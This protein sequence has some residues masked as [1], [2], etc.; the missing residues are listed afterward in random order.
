MLTYSLMLNP[1]A[2]P[3]RVTI[4][5][6]PTA[7]RSRRDKLDAVIAELEKLGC[8]VNVLETTAPGHAEKIAQQLDEA[9]VDI[10]AAAGGDGTVNEVV[11]G[12]K[13]KP[14]ALAVI[15][16][17]TAN[18]LADEVGLG[19]KAK[20]VAEAIAFGG[21]RPIRVGNAN[22]RRFVM[23]AGAGFDAEVVDGVQLSLKKVIGPL[24][25]VWE[26]FRQV[27]IYGWAGCCVEVDGET[28]QVVSAIVCNGRSYGGPFI[29]APEASLEADCF[30]VVMFTRS[31]WFNVVRYGVALVMGRLPRLSDVHIVSGRH[32]VIRGGDG[33]P[34]QADG[35]I[36]TRLPATIEV[37]AEPVR[38]AFPA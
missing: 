36:L 10:L 26:M 16:L 5:F 9:T 29:A 22:G 27:F 8:P 11:N 1:H 32:V 13:G 14:V 28:H 21:V 6:N 4:V 23:M 7:G 2:A 37:D 38:L 25:Y 31:G 24:A 3:R 33:S 34:V 30:Q 15:P 17:G 20:R 35:D 12:I 19:R 18:V